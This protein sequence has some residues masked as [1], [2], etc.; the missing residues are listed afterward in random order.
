MV[1]LDLTMLPVLMV[2]ERI[3]NCGLLVYRGPRRYRGRGKKVTQQM[4]TGAARTGSAETERKYTWVSV[5]PPFCS[6]LKGRLLWGM[7]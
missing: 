5:L 1:S 6:F 3:P 2:S 4:L 7:L